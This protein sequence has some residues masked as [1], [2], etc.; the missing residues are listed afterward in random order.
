MV[1]QIDKNKGEVYQK[2]K[3]KEED[4]TSIPKIKEKFL[5]QKKEKTQN[6]RLKSDVWKHFTRQVMKQNLLVITARKFMLLNKKKRV[7]SILNHLKE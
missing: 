4:G 2:E 6:G 1:S 7:S 5:V 3:S